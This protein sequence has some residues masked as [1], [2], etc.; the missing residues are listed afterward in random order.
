MDLVSFFAGCGGLDLGFEQMGFRVVW[1]NELE[2]HCRATYIRNHPNT[3]FVLE[4]ICK[5]NSDTIPNCDGFIGGP[6][7]QSWSVGGKQKGLDDKRGK[8]FLK[9]IELI[10]V[11][12]PKFFVIE[13]VKGML[14]D[15]FKDVF[16]DFLNRLNDAG[17]N[18]QWKLLD[19]VNYRIPQNRERVFIVGF[20]KDLNVNFTF[21]NPTCIESITLENAIGD[22]TVEPRLCSSANMKYFDG[23]IEK[24][25]LYRNHD[26]LMS[27][28]GPFYL[29][30]NRRR[31]WRQP[32]F[33]INATADFAPLHPSS[34]K[35]MYYGYE[36]W[37]FQKDKLSKYRRMSVREC[38][39]IQTFPDNFIFEYENVKDG[40]KMIGNAVPPRLGK[41]IA[42][43]ILNAFNGIKQEHTV[44]CRRHEN[45][46]NE[47]VLVGYYKG[48]RHKQLILKNQLY[49][50]RS[51]GRKGSMF[52]DECSLMPKYL[53]LHY[54]ENVEIYEL[55]T[56][57]PV[58]ANA[59]FLKTLGF[60]TSGETYLCFR[61]KSA[62]PIMIR[63]IVNY[64]TCLRFDPSDYIPYFTTIKELLV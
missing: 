22:I 25:C 62:E 1:A 32:S 36:N 19:A 46:I 34:P 26:V 56:E 30:G 7:C 28:F 23:E 44:N 4:D 47:T 48:D 60:E 51:D 8:L 11:K 42:K 2:P 41:E 17:Y 5:I 57:E 59:S 18:V 29:K 14:D 24:N 15:K 20:R 31:G 64:S 52:K 39:R 3:E 54:K 45:L 50:V 10:S 21:P 13:N 27:E 12:K 53:F 58:L 33:T 6:P 55:D 38:A 61:L 35:M 40:Y 43:S 37:G 49:Y 63:D 9:Y 16:N